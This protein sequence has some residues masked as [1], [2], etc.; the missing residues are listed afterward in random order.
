[1]NDIRDAINMLHRYKTVLTVNTVFSG[2][3]IGVIVYL[4]IR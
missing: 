2:I 4:V 1:M 3:L